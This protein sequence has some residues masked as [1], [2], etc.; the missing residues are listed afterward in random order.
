MPNLFSIALNTDTTLHAF[1]NRSGNPFLVPSR[2]AFDHSIAKNAKRSYLKPID[3]FL[4]A[5]KD[6]DRFYLQ[7]TFALGDVLQT[8]PVMR[9]LNSL[10]HNCYLR[11]A[12]QYVPT[13][14][15]MGVNAQRIRTNGKDYGLILDGTVERDHQEPRLQAYHRIDQYLSAIG[16]KEENIV[17]D[18]SCDISQFDAVADD[19]VEKPYIVFQGRGSGPRKSLPNETIDSIIKLGNSDNVRIAVVGG[20]E[21]VISQKNYDSSKTHVFFKQLNLEQLFWL[22]S[23][24]QCLVCMD[25]SPL[26]VSHFTST[27]VVALLGATRS[28]QRIVYHPLYPEGAASIEL[29]RYVD[30]EPCFES[31]EACGGKY[32]CLALS[33]AKIYELI[34]PHIRKYI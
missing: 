10:N 32:S 24:A 34:K 2:A 23:K 4:S 29:S 5:M 1:L 26:W 21:G 6:E 14:R 28:E 30:C 9:Y 16:V 33:P 7:R 31:A 3:N 12:S 18:W 27:P 15:K 22:I 13:L 19:F 25:S 17:F 20:A 8:V 11:T